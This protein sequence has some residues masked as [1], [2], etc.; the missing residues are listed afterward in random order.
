MSASL[1]GASAGSA[2]LGEAIG[3][4]R[5]QT[6]RRL[7]DTLYRSVD[8][9]IS[10]A[11]AGNPEYAKH[12]Q[13]AGRQEGVESPVLKS[14]MGQFTTEAWDDL[15]AAEQRGISMFVFP[16]HVGVNLIP[17]KDTSSLS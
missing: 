17:D 9:A 5:S 13:L 10:G 4:G 2:S 16:T 14:L 3:R 12:L 6:G 1:F 11:R 8:D 7:F 15:R